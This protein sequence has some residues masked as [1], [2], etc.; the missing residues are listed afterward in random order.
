VQDQVVTAGGRVLGVTAVAETVGQ[1][2]GRAYDAVQ[3]ITFQDMHCRQD[4][5]R[6]R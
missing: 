6:T 1:A 4:I 3:P 5:G 2:I